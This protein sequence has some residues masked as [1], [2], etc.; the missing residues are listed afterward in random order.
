MGSNGFWNVFYWFQK[1]SARGVY[2][3]KYSAW[4][5]HV[6]VNNGIRCVIGTV[7]FPT[8]T[9]FSKVNQMVC[10]T[11]SKSMEEIHQTSDNENKKKKFFSCLSRSRSYLYPGNSICERD[12]NRKV[13]AWDT[14]PRGLIIRQ[15]FFYHGVWSTADISPCART[16]G[17]NEDD[18]NY[19]NETIGSHD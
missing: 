2:F 19:K 4:L 18:D 15:T 14:F 17:P 6:S 3:G 12:E 13:P 11:L 5:E 10:R 16:C 7:H 9:N 1:L 8:I